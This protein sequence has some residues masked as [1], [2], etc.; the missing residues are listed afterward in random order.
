VGSNPLA[1]HFRSRKCLFVNGGQLSRSYQ[2]ECL[3]FEMF[4]NF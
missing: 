4:I 2:N 3:S 1:F